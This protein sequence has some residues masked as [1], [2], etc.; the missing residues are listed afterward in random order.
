MICNCSLA[1]T[2]ACQNCNN[3][4]LYE[5]S[6]FKELN[7]R[8]GHIPNNICDFQNDNGHSFIEVIDTEIN[9]PILVPVSDIEI[10]AKTDDGKCIINTIHGYRIETAETYEEIKNKLIGD[11]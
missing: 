1:G 9:H 3:R 8:V 4:N 10:I 5:G 7:L 2:A 11:H 6:T